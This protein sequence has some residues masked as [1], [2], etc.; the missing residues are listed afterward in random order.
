MKIGKIE[1]MKSVPKFSNAN[2]SFT[3]DNH[4]NSNKSNYTNEITYNIFTNKAIFSELKKKKPIEKEKVEDLSK[5]ALIYKKDNKNNE[6]ENSPIEEAEIIN[7]FIVQVKKVF[8]NN[9]LKDG[10]IS[11][12]IIIQDQ[13]IMILFL[14]QSELVLINL[15][16][17]GYNLKLTPS[18][19][20]SQ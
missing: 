9:L 14:L 18:Q 4:M 15:H 12:L 11:T 16:Q 19:I 20:K 8:S 1:K 10:K 13:R 6:E 5:L 7:K 2:Q 3:I 17:P